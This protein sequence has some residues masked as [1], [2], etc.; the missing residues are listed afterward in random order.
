VLELRFHWTKAD[1]APGDCMVLKLGA[2]DESMFLPLAANYD[3]DFTGHS[4][5]ELPFFQG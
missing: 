4:T 1:F 2:N 3:V 5:L